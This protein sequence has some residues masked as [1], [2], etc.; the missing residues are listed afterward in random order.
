M[1]QMNYAF[2]EPDPAHLQRVRDQ[3]A[4]Y[5]GGMGAR[6]KNFY[7]SLASRYGYEAVAKEI[8]ELYLSGKKAEAAAAIPDEILHAVSLSGDANH[9]RA[10]VAAF[11]AAGVTTFRLNQ[12]AA[13]AERRLDDAAKLPE[14][15]EELS[16]GNEGFDT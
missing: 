1:L 16:C 14:R 6:G 11:M 3:L 13:S 9:V 15:T 8:L 12:L 4:L 10:R 7:N 5:I 2:G